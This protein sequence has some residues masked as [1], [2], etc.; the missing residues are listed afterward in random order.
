MTRVASNPLGTT[1]ADNSAEGLAARGV[2]SS[3]MELAKPGIVKMVAITAGLGFA[4]AAIAVDPASVGGWWGVA[5]RGVV[6]L[7]GVSLAAGGANALNQAW[8]A[9]RDALMERTKDRPI[10][11]GR[12]SRRSAWIAGVVLSVLGCGL[13]W[14]FTTPGA[15]AL[16]AFTVLSYVLIYTP[17]KTVTVYSTWVG[18]LP[19]AMPPVIGWSAAMPGAW[20]A[21][22]PSNA[23]WAAWGIVALMAIWQLPHFAAIAWKYRDD[24][25]RGGYQ[26]LSVVDPT[27]RR[28][29]RCAVIWSGILLPVSLLPA[30]FLHERLTGIF[31]VAVIAAGIW[32]FRWSVEF[33]EKRTDALARQ[34]FFAS[35]VYLP[36][37]LLA[38]VLDAGVAA[39]M[40]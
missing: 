19:G 21:F 9:N 7:L 20:A 17:L 32:M 18:T 11:S 22:E 15:A 14:A 40:G 34:V 6:C 10:P 23:M 2:L 37:A 3:V 38:L 39:V 1:S 4:L 13:L 24:Y 16:T 30:A 31:V 5:I 35:L 8:E 33:A 27:G 29:A 12:L 25:A 28:T 26:V 36:L